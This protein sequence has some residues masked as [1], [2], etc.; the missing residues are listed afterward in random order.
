[1]LFSF[2]L[3]CI[4]PGISSLSSLRFNDK[5]YQTI[6]FDYEFSES[7]VQQGAVDSVDYEFNRLELVSR[8]WGAV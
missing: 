8:G 3:E 7:R 6:I 4:P 5:F 2:I 1:M